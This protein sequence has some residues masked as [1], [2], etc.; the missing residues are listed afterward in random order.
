ML[1]C[2]IM[3]DHKDNTKKGDTLYFKYLR[4][5]RFFIINQNS[6]TQNNESFVILPENIALMSNN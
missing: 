6:L 4:K 2:K 3:A 5:D 1:K